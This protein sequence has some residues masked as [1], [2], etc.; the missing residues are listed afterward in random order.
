LQYK[1]DAKC[2]EKSEEKKDSEP[3]QILK[4]QLFKKD[5]WDDEDY[6]WKE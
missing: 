3:K 2:D 4:T 1:T 5:E 6:E